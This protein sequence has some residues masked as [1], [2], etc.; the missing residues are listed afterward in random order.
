LAAKLEFL[1]KVSVAENR[2]L[3]GEDEIKGMSGNITGDRRVGK[4][5]GREEPS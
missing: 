5:K 2:V 4:R 1:V 3:T